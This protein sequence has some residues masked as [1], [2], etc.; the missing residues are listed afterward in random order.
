MR[1]TFWSGNLKIRDH[2]EVTGADWKIAME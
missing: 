2:L 1:T